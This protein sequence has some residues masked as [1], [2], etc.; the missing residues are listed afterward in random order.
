MLYDL[1]FL[2]LLFL[3]GHRDSLL[4][5]AY[6]KLQYFTQ[7]ALWFMKKKT[8]LFTGFIAIILFG[9]FLPFVI[10]NQPKINPTGRLDDTEKKPFNRTNNKPM[11]Q[12]QLSAVLIPRS[13]KSDLANFLC[14]PE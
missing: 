13:S 9:I 8:S 2:A 11:D 14:K 12:P 1:I 3:C 6:S 5:T 10:K 7:R 4:H